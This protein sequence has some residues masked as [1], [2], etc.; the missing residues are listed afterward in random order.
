[1]TRALTCYQLLTTAA[2]PFVPFYLRLRKSRG[3]EDASRFGERLGFATRQRPEGKLIWLHAASVGEANSVQPLI[4]TLRRRYP[5]VALLLT[6]G[7]VTSAKLMLERL[8]AG[9]IHQFVPVDMPAAVQRFASHWKPD[10]ALLV[11]SELWPNLLAAVHAAGCRMVLVNARMSQ[12]SYFRWQRFRRLIA[13]MLGWFEAV[14]AQSEEDAARFR[15]LGALQVECLGN[16][17]YDSQPL[18]ADAKKMVALEEQVAG[19]PKW[20]A[21]SIHPG[22]DAIIAQAHL[23]LKEK[24]PNLLTLVVPRH[25][26]RGALMQETFSLSGLWVNRRAAGD[27]LAPQA[28]VYIADTLGELGLFYR[29]APAVFIGGSLVPHGGQN[30]LEPARLGCALLFGPHMFNFADIAGGLKAADAAKEVSDAATLAAALKTLLSDPSRM[31]GMSARASAWVIGK[32]GVNER[33]LEKLSPLVD[34][35]VRHAA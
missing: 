11:E 2:S 7:T 25:P 1:M 34:E 22:E 14:Y 35:V 29:L 31:A 33:L 21:A 30:P 24:F 9:V 20:L 27:A 15:L 32:A 8:P 5:A 23:L 16:L 4:D 26:E 18:P 19:R 13:Q 3:K 12:R 6:T 10:A 28:E 17:K